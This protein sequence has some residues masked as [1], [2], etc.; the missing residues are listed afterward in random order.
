M[1]I[2]IDK[3]GET[4][5]TGRQPVACAEYYR[6]FE[7]NRPASETGLVHNRDRICLIRLTDAHLRDAHL[8]DIRL[9]DAYLKNTCLKNVY[10]KD[11]MWWPRCVHPEEGTVSVTG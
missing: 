4:K 5:Q 7:L 2:Y 8:K 11:V 1:S 6:W 10:L 9:R 3:T